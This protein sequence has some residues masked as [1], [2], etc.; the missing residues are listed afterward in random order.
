MNNN[1]LIEQF[2]YC[3]SPKLMSHLVNNKK[4]RYLHK[5]INDK[6]GK[7][8]W[9]FKRDTRLK[10]VLNEWTLNKEPNNQ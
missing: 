7:N 6:T 8:F 10:D 2:F 5:G 9:L 1:N 4:I 3:Y